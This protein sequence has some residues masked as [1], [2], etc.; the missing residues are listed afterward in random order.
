M[1]FNFSLPWPASQ[2]RPPADD[3]AEHCICAWAAEDIRRLSTLEYHQLRLAVEQFGLRSAKAQDL[4]VPITEIGR[5]AAAGQTLL[6]CL[7]HAGSGTLLGGLKIGRKRL[8]IRRANGAMVEMEPLC[9]LDFYV[10]ESC[11]RLG[12]GRALLEH[13][14]ASEG[15]PPER[16]AYDRPSPKLTA[17]LAR[18]Y[19]LSSYVPQSNNFVVFD[20]YFD[21]EPPAGDARQSRHRSGGHQPHHHHRRSGDG[22]GGGA[23]AH[24]CGGD[25]RHWAS[26]TNRPLTDREAAAAPGALSAAATAVVAPGAGERPTA[27]AAAH[28]FP[29]GDWQRFP[30]GACGGTGFGGVAHHALALG[31]DGAPWGSIPGSCSSSAGS[32]PAEAASR[33]AASDRAC[34]AREAGA[35][36][37][38]GWGSGGSSRE[39]GARPDAAP[40]TPPLAGSRMGSRHLTCQ[41]AT[42]PILGGSSATYYYQQQQQQQQE[43]QIRGRPSAELRSSPGTPASAAPSGALTPPWAREEWGQQSHVQ[44]TQQQHTQQQQPQAARATYPYPPYRTAADGGISYGPAT[45]T[46]FAPRAPP[47]PLPRPAAAGEFLPAPGGP[48]TMSTLQIAALRDR[49]LLPQHRAGASLVPTAP[50]QAALARGR[51][52]SGGGGGGGALRISGAALA[53]AACGG[54]GGAAASGAG[55]PLSAKSLAA[56]QRAGRGAASCLSYL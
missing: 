51:G 10:H 41:E 8:F 49:G 6:L 23:T 32:T 52:G 55:T 47:A 56:A 38:G 14:L 24:R 54:G 29:R 39:G 5:L 9:V 40:F 31:A 36:S 34:A 2:A 7:P 1:E 48:P 33:A 45:P 13:V 11:Q 27:A 30:A 46:G 20:R 42:N 21:H 53:A 18:H 25:A 50:M 28:A 17:F 15:L 12:I 19:G 35:R 44:H 26:V 4:P 22:V 16:L 43:R 3:A 37:G